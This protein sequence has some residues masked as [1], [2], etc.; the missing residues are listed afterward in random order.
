MILILK[1]EKVLNNHDL[2]PFNVATRKINELDYL[3]DPRVRF[4]F[5]KTFSSN[6]GFAGPILF[7]CLNQV[8][9]WAM[10]STCN[11]RE[12]DSSA[13]QAF[14]EKI[15]FKIDYNLMNVYKSISIVFERP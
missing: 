4:P 11:Q 1:M 7:F 6:T 12:G 9:A 15:T 8:Q 5:Q 2:L 14:W 13:T 3:S 10:K